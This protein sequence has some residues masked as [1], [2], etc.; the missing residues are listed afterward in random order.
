MTATR[1]LLKPVSK[2]AF[3]LIEILAASTIMV[4]L[5]GIVAYITGSVMDSWNRASGKLS[6]NAE[7]RLV[8]EII[9]QDL[10]AAVLKNNGQQWL[11]VEG[12]AA[13]EAG[14]P[15]ASNSV[16]LKLFAPAFDR[17]SDGGGICAIS[18]KVEYQES[19]ANGPLT[20]ALYR[21]VVTPQDPLDDYLSSGYENPATSAQGTL[22]GSNSLADW[23]NGAITAESNYLAANIVEFKVLIYDLN[24]AEPQPRN[25]DTNNNIVS[26]D[27]Y[28]YG[29]VDSNAGSYVPVYADIILT[30]VTDEGAE[31][32]KTKRIDG[33]LTR[34]ID[35]VPG[36]ADD[37]V[38]Q[39]GETLIRR[40]YF[41]S[42]PI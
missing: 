21:R 18:Y 9:A 31:M 19:Y 5:V 35:L 20:Y 22:G 34:I 36:T 1:T 37:V 13:L 38:T 17:Q 3:T 40:V 2:S 23:S 15:F 41:K 6:V 11:R 28:V 39:N 16:V 30:V 27:N 26:N 29:G 25:G 32:L 8:L 33:L 7:A 24:P 10:E 14:A 12:P 4:I 42:N